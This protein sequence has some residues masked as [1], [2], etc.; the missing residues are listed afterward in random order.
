MKIQKFNEDIKSGKVSAELLSKKLGK[1]FFSELDEFDRIV[2]EI[3]EH[4][5][6]FN[7]FICFTEIYPETIIQ[8]E[9]L[10]LYIGFR[11]GQ[12][13]LQIDEFEYI[14]EVRIFSEFHLPEN[15]INHYLEKL[16]IEEESNKYNL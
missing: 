14:K 2:F 10:D 1:K 9:E 16:K 3:D 6:S 5:E 7:F 8:L 12:W 13:S 11:K 4:L 15:A